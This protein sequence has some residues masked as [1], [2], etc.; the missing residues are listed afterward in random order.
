MGV[1]LWQTSVLICAVNSWKKLH[2]LCAMHQL[3]LVLRQADALKQET[4]LRKT[5][6]VSLSLKA[7]SQSVYESPDYI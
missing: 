6:H 7:T 3:T 5:S 2:I 4:K 1:L